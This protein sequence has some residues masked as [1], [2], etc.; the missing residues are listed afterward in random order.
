MQISLS[1][2]VNHVDTCIKGHLEMYKLF[3][4]IHE[5]CIKVH[6]QSNLP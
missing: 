1:G 4:I 3:H 5:V 6:L 2:H